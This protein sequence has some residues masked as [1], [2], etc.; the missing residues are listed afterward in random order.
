MRAADRACRPDLVRR[1]ARRAAESDLETGLA[2]E[3]WR[4]TLL[5]A[6]LG[7]MTP[8]A[9]L[10]LGAPDIVVRRFG[11]S[12]ITSKGK[13]KIRTVDDYSEALVNSA[14][15]VNR[16]IRMDSVAHLV[17]ATRRLVETAPGSRR[18]LGKS[19][20][21]SAYRCCPIATADLDLAWTVLLHPTT[22][23]VWRSQRLACPFGAIGSVYAWD[24]LGEAFV[25]IARRRLLDV[26]LRYVDDLFFPELDVLA[27]GLRQRLLDLAGALGLTLDL[28]KTP[29]PAA[30]LPALGV[31]VDLV[32][33]DAG[34][35]SRRAR[36]G[37]DPA[38]LAVW[39]AAHPALGQAPSP[40]RALPHAPTGPP[41]V[42]AL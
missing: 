28:D 27:E 11:V 6:D 18:L 9:L 15:E 34:V 37:P 41:T 39:L 42:P 13:A 33:P 25:R 38:K 17:E 24:R 5:E 7:R 23:E 3:I 31:V 14:A 36:L 21:S 30:S 32:G 22:G 10:E 29:H 40:V 2:S 20:F 4:Q 26:L 8:R 1:R 12:Q 35:G 19:E 16:R